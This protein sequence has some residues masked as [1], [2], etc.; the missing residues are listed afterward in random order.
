M[1]VENDGFVEVEALNKNAI[2]AQSFHN[3][4]VQRPKTDLSKILSK[5][6][7]IAYST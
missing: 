7:I 5:N 4:L 6:F 3:L 2:T 1:K